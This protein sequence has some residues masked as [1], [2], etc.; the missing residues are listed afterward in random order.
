MFVIGIGGCVGC[1]TCSALL[2]DDTRYYDTYDDYSYDYDYDYNYD[3]LDD[4]Y[5]DEETIDATLTL[6]EIKGLAADEPSKIEEGKCTTGAF[7]VGTGKDIGAGLYF[8]EGNQ[9]E[10]GSFMVF[11]KESK[12][13]Y[14]LVSSVVYFGNYYA[15]LESDEVIVFLTPV[16]AKFYPAS[17]STMVVGDVIESGCY[18]VGIDIPAGDYTVS[19]Q[20]GF[21]EDAS[22]ESGVYVMKDLEWDDDSIIESKNIIAG[23]THT[24]TAKEGQYVE[25]YGAVMSA[26]AAPV[27]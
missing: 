12:D 2:Y 13:S 7:E 23:G 19:Y 18:R 6:E 9:T 3:Y 27:G 17:E 11:E 26:A 16:D 24:I 21:V 8:L 5:D 14:T 20:K 4:L 1:V 10:E 25:L 22:Q 15:E